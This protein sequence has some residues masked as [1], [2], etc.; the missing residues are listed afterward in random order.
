[1]L[2]LAGTLTAALARLLP[3]TWLARVIAWTLRSP[4]MTLQAP[5]LG[6]VGVGTAT[7]GGTTGTVVGLPGA[8]LI[9]LAQLLDSAQSGLA[10]VTQPSLLFHGRAQRGKGGSSILL[11]RRLAGRVESVM[12]D[13]EL[14]DEFDGSGVGR[15]AA[16]DHVVDGIVERSARFVA[17]VLEEN[18]TKRGNQLRRERIASRSNAA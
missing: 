13:D 15:T 6:F 2:P 1:M 7:S 18:E 16:H 3:Q 9:D 4:S 5:A 12:V 14:D 8:V 10:S 17:T 11:Q